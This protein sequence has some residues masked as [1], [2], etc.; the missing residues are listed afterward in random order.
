MTECCPNRP[1][2]LSLLSH[3][4]AGRFRNQPL[5]LHLSCTTDLVDSYYQNLRPGESPE[6]VMVAKESH[7]LWSILRCVDAQEQVECIVDSGCQIIAMSEEVCHDLHIRYDPTVILN[8]QSANGSVN[9]SLGLAQNMPC[10]IGDIT[11][12][13]QIHIIW[14]PAYDIL[15][16]RP[17]DVLTCS[18]V[19]TNSANKTIITITDPNTQIVTAIPSFARGQHRRQPKPPVKMEIQNFRILSRK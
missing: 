6:H 12:Y 11:L 5:S 18:S 10:T 3:P 7:S 9:P 4:V 13:L 19:K 16:G 8:M 1:P 2:H 15:L 17:F 14:N